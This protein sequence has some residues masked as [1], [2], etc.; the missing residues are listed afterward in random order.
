MSAGRFGRGAH[1]VEHVGAQG[2]VGTV[3]SWAMLM[4][5][6]T[7]RERWLPNVRM[8]IHQGGET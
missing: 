1:A 6:I 2:P 4:W 8:G 3:G 5:R 7:A